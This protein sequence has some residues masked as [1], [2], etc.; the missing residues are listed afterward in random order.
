M[1][2]TDIQII[3]TTRIFLS[4]RVFVSSLEQTVLFLSLFLFISLV[5]FY[6]DCPSSSR[7]IIIGPDSHF[8][9]LLS[10]TNLTFRHIFL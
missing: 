1:L 10:N 7:K 2:G 3:S 5:H 6:V 8:S 4:L 9:S